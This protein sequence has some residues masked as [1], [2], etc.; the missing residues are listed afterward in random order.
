[1][2]TP[3]TWP[4]CTRSGVLDARIRYQL[5]SVGLAEDEDLLFVLTTN[6]PDLIEPALAARPGRVD[7]A[8][9]IPLPDAD[10]RRRLPTAASARRTQ[11]PSHPAH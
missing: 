4:C 11:L 7:L 3:T 10:G 6:R 1:L 2:P 5:G 8:L 9:E